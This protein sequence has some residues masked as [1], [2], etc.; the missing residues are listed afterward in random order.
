MKLKY[1][2]WI[3]LGTII[4]ALFLTSVV[5]TTTVPA[6]GVDKESTTTIWN[7]MWENLFTNIPTDD[8]TDTLVGLQLPEAMALDLIETNGTGNSVM[9]GLLG[10]L[11]IL[12]IIAGV[13]LVSI[14]KELK[15]WVLYVPFG[16]I[17]VSGWTIWFTAPSKLPGVEDMYNSLNA[18]NPA[19]PATMGTMMVEGNELSMGLGLLV[20]SIGSLYGIVALVLNKLGKIEA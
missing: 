19:F 10:L 9:S 16:L 2:L 4:I 11:P 13:V 8:V 18:I 7:L 1:H 20:I 5:S 3:A 14:K 17:F 15:E 6:L 12:A